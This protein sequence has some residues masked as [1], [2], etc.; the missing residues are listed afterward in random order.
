VFN[1]AMKHAMKQVLQGLLVMFVL[2]MLPLQVHALGLGKLEVRSYLDE[3]FRG[4]IELQSLHG[5]PLQNN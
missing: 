1:T 5:Q 3:P 4:E 2:L